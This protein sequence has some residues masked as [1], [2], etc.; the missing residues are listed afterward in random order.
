MSFADYYFVSHRTF[1]PIVLLMAEYD[2]F[3]VFVEPF[4]PKSRAVSHPPSDDEVAGHPT[5][6]PT[7]PRNLPDSCWGVFLF[8]PGKLRKRKDSPFSPIFHLPSLSFLF[9]GPID[10]VERGD[11][12]RKEAL[13]PFST[14]RGFPV[15]LFTVT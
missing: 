12:P 4:S 3:T 2:T 6:P 13:A 9:F 14:S 5:L 11:L 7:S 1:F 8:H 10:S 15:F